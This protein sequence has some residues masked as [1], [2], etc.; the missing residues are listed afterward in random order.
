MWYSVLRQCTAGRITPAPASLRRKSVRPYKRVAMG[1]RTMWGCSSVWF[2]LTGKQHVQERA[3][4]RHR[5]SAR[6]ALPVAGSGASRQGW[7][8][9]SDHAQQQEGKQAGSWRQ[10][11]SPQGVGRV[12]EERGCWGRGSAQDEHLRVRGGES[13]ARWASDFQ[14]PGPGAGSGEQHKVSQL[15]A[16]TMA[17]SG[18]R[19]D[20]PS[21]NITVSCTHPS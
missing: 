7:N 9:S 13:R 6:Q 12:Q 1:R 3:P 4:V 21:V 19:S 8:H 2:Q 20:Q 18:R 14:G 5:A 11:G 17:A 15:W 10:H 16:G